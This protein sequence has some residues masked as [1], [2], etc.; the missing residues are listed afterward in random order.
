[1]K[2]QNALLIVLS[3]FL[4][5]ACEAPQNSNARLIALTT[6]V[7]EMEYIA[8]SRLED[9]ELIERIKG[10]VLSKLRDPDSAQFRD[11]R[12]VRNDTQAYLCGQVNSRNSFWGY[13]G[14]QWFFASPI[15]QVV[16]EE[17]DRTGSVILHFCLSSVQ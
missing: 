12:L 5:A 14:F 15:S 1:M 4:L 16:M 13:T 11:L 10:N 17:N 8:F 7:V 9:D 6:E 2:I 3:S